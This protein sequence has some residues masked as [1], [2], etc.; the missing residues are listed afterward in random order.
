MPDQSYISWF[1]EMSALY[2]KDRKAFME[3][4]AAMVNDNIKA[5]PERLRPQ[6]RDLQREIDARRMMSDD[7]IQSCAAIYE[8]MMD[9][10]FGEEGLR[11]NVLRLIKRVES[12]ILEAEEYRRINGYQ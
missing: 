3:K 4:R 7:A 12:D 8:M 10:Y 2:Q 11:E 9:K 6:L 5:A 1:D